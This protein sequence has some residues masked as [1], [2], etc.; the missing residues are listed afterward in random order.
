MKGDE[1]TIEVLF[2]WLWGMASSRVI[3]SGLLLGLF[4]EEVCYR[5]FLIKSVAAL[6]SRREHKQIN[7]ECP[8]P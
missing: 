8:M 4:Q 3:N 1:R 7:I 2:Q 6:E 5:I